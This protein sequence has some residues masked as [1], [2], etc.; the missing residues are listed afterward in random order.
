MGI[1]I[2]EV[3]ADF[4]KATMPVD[5]RTT[6]PFGILHGGASCVLSETLG[7]IA[8][9]MAIDHEKFSAVGIEISASHLRAISNSYVKAICK[10]I[11]LGRKLH[12]WQ[13]DL[14]SEETGKHICT[15]KLTTMIVPKTRDLGQ[16][17]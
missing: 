12:V 6:Q 17:G 10:P 7:S 16:T 13:I 3:G 5:D 2:T 8:S 4:L 14:Y 11:R 9:W 1:E 15:S